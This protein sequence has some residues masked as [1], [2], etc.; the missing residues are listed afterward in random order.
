MVPEPVIIDTAH[1]P[2]TGLISVKDFF[3]MGDGRSDDYL[4]IINA[5]NYCIA[6]PKICRE[7]RFP[8]G[9]NYRTTKPF[10]LQNAGKYFT[11]TLKGDFSNKSCSDQYTSKIICDYKSGYGIG[12]QYGRGITIENLTIVGKYSLPVSLSTKTLGTLKFTDWIDSTITETRYTPY[13]GISVDPDQNASGT[14]GGTSD[15]T[16]KNCAIFNWM[17]DIVLS[18]NGYTLNDEMVNIL[19]NNFGLSRVAI[20]VCQDQAKTIK[21]SGLKCWGGVHTILDGVSYG[22][23]TGGGSVFCDNW[24]IAGGVNEIFNVT[25]GRF[26]L[27]AINIYGESVFRFG[28]VGVG[29]GANIIN[30]EIDFLTGS[31]MPAA[32]YLIAGQA[33]FYGGSLRYYDDQYNHRMNLVSFG[34][35]MRD[36]TLNNPP[37]TKGLYGSAK[38]PVPILDNIH[39]FY[40]SGSDTVT[41]I[42]YITDLVVDRI[43]WKATLTA[44]GLVVGD[45]VL[46]SPASTTGSYYD[47]YLVHQ[48]CPTIQIGRIISVTGNSVT[49][50]DVGLN[51]YSGQGYDAF[52]VDRLK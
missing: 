32:D 47:P 11:I 14:R 35:A 16:I 15:V 38:Y 49:L 24:N 9:G 22:I 21:I 6:N 42:G 26:P 13:A 34:G 50:D 48:L 46:A 25:T 19:D 18:P 31:G 44:A 8:A 5:C 4:P 30:V 20:A 2:N 29:C 23:G 7:V 17:V 12:I 28:N 1:I 43:N 36:M 39:Y 33:N 27:S 3:A 10:L 37:I 40:T 41:K 45:Y 51:C 52:Y